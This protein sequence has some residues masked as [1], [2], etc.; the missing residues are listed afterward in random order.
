MCT[1]RKWTS[2][3]STR[4]A[5]WFRRCA[6]CA[7]APHCAPGCWTARSTRSAPTTRRST[8][9]PSSCRSPRPRR[10]RPFALF[11]KFEAKLEEFNGN[12]PRAAVELA[13][14]WRTDRVLRHLEALLL[15]A[16]DKNIF[17]LSGN[18]D[19]IEP[20]EDVA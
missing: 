6:A 9:M 4:T 15:V 18:G 19:V 10:V 3:S 7:T 20:D 12:L 17:I 8:R 14:D 5:T 2:V 11:A 13:K 16:D 1:C